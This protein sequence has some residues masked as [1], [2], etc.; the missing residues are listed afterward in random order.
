MLKDECMN[1]LVHLFAV[2][3]GSATLL[4]CGNYPGH[5]AVLAVDAAIT[6][7]SYHNIIS[8]KERSYRRPL[9]RAYDQAGT[10]RDHGWKFCWS[11][12]KH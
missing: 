1:P 7:I 6:K 10:A 2:V 4:G 12:R 11:W 9:A 3:E 8:Y 5:S